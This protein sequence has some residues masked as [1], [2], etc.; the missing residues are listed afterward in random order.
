M[1]NGI[2]RYF[3]PDLKNCRNCCIQLNCA[4]MTIGVSFAH[5]LFT[6]FAFKRRVVVFQN[7]KLTLP[8]DKDSVLV[9][10]KCRRSYALNLQIKDNNSFPK[11]SSYKFQSYK[12]DNRCTSSP[13]VLYLSVF[14][15][16]QYLLSH[17]TS[18]AA[19]ELKANETNN[20]IGGNRVK[21]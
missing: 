12:L 18:S 16:V 8:D 6:F 7:Q 1:L 21:N 4:A 19:V 2:L 17:F 13:P 20:S 15:G 10:Y 11:G 5:K 14:R 3:V 9:C